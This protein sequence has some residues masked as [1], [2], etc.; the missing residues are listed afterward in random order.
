MPVL[1]GFT[2]TKNIYTEIFKT[3]FNTLDIALVLLQELF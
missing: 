3:D 2:N 1:E